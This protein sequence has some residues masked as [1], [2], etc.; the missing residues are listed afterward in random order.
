MSS[1]ENWDGGLYMSHMYNDHQ[2]CKVMSMH[3][4]FRYM[5]MYMYV[6]G[7]GGFLILASPGRW[8]MLVGSNA[9]LNPP[10][11]F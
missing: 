1:L 8:K 6:G 3:S 10:F 9:H 5:Y 11:F 7:G 2:I 4:C